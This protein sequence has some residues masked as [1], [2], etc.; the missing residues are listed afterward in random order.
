MSKLKEKIRPT[1][2]IAPETQSAPAVLPKKTAPPAP[3]TKSVKTQEPKQETPERPKTY[4]VLQGDTLK[5]IAQKI[6]GDPG[7][8]KEIYN[9]NKDKVERGSVAPDQVLTIP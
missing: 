4:T 3:K 5:S 8:W 2:P 1:A 9:A 7:R 6:Y